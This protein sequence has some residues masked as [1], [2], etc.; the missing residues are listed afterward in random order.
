M[1]S[2]VI[3]YRKITE[4]LSYPF[5]FIS[6]FILVVGLLPFIKTDDFT[7]LFA[8]VL[9]PFYI[10]YNVNK[11]AEKGIICSFCTLCSDVIYYSFSGVHFSIL[12]CVLLGVM[13]SKLVSEMRLSYIFVSLFTGSTVLAFGAG[14]IYPLLL[15]YL[16]GFSSLIS[17]KSFLFGM[18][19]NFYDLAFSDKLSQLFY[20]T[21]FGSSSL[22]AKG[23]LSGAV[24]IFKALPE[25]VS[26]SRYLTGKYFVNIFLTLGLFFA[27]YKRLSVNGK[28]A[29]IS[30]CTAGILTGD[31]RPFSLFI[32]IFNPF[33]YLAYLFVIGISYFIPEL[34]NLKIGFTDNGSI[35]ELFKYGNN[36]AYFLITG[37]VL[38]LLMYF[39][40]RLVMS[41]FSLSDGNYYPAKVRKIISS[42]GGED[43]ITEVKRGRVKVNNPNLINIITLDCDIHGNMVVLDKDDFELIEEYF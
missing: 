27:L 31:V 12:F 22:S 15:E 42:L 5:I 11:S 13:M 30:V 39:I 20:H 14:L 25:N 41:K 21:D 7:G 1:K 26:V 28:L 8:S 2:T 16:K 9:F 40:C 33:I 6:A 43:N 34:I 38:A 19:N 17:G 23:I 29:F 10:V 36:W 18:I 24:D 32:L 3:I 4:Y 37:F 35:I